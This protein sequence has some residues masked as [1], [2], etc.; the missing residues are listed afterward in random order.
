MSWGTGTPESATLGVQGPERSLSPC[1]PPAPRLCCLVGGA[2]GE[3]MQGAVWV[4][5]CGLGVLQPCSLLLLLACLRSSMVCRG[6]GEVGDSHGQ[7]QLG[8]VV[9]FRASCWRRA[10]GKAEMLPRG[11]FVPPPGVITPRLKSSAPNTLGEHPPVT[12]NTRRQGRAS[13]HQPAPSTTMGKPQHHH[14]P[15]PHPLPWEAQGEQGLAGVC[16]KG[17][18]GTTSAFP[19]TGQPFL[20]T[21]P[22][23]LPQP[24]MSSGLRPGFSHSLGQARGLG[25]AATAGPGAQPFL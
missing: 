8:S 25:G 1:C 2:S 22:S 3:A 20:P 21:P 16:S 5:A 15:D 9:S 11:T 6:N 23:L 7:S 13:K 12:H 24:R 18:R 19:G 14:G 4:L 10:L 17:Q